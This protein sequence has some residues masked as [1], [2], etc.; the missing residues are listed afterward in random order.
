MHDARLI[1]GALDQ[2]ANTG[3]YLLGG[4]VCSDATGRALNSVL[5]NLRLNSNPQS[6]RSQLAAIPLLVVEERH[7]HNG[8][9]APAAPAT[10]PSG[11][12]DIPSSPGAGVLT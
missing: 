12:P 9:L 2:A 1:Q 4:D 3:V 11:T 10:L 6:L 8:V 7:Y 5:N